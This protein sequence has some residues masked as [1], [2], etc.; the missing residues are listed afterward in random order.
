MFC[1]SMSPQLGRCFPI[2]MK[3]IFWNSRGLI[4]IEKR[5]KL[6]SIIRD[7][8]PWV[9]AVCETHIEDLSD[10]LTRYLDGHRR[11]NWIFSPSSGQ[12]G[13]IILGWTPGNITQVVFRLDR[14]C[15]RISYLNTVSGKPA[16]LA[17]IHMPCDRAEK[18]TSEGLLVIGSSRFR[19]TLAS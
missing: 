11:R 1:I 5:R 4:T 16:H 10:A 18:I 8:D 9:I 13:G 6:R 14:H 3:F 19:H 17:A 12:S 2:L 15:I 7:H